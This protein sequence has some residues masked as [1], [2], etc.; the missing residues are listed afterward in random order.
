MKKSLEYFFATH[1]SRAEE[2]WDTAM[3]SVDTNVLLGMFRLTND[4]ANKLMQTL[5]ECASLKEKNL[6]LTKQVLIEF[7]SNIRMA[8][9]YAHDQF[10][11]SE[12]FLENSKNKLKSDIY[13]HLKSSGII[14]EKTIKRLKKSM[15]K[16][17]DLVISELKES[18]K[19]SEYN[20]ES[21]LK[22]VE[23]LQ[24]IFSDKVLTH[25]IPSQ[26]DAQK[27][28]KDGHAPSGKD[29]Q[30]PSSISQAGDAII[31]LELIEHAKILS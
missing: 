30:K 28:I 5:E 16:E 20:L 18:Q 19:S 11:K 6:F 9:K 31:W 22:I 3:L 10:K 12:E 17:I 1:P 13:G 2:A 26:E 14:P 25:E 27:L 7:K 15:N 4:T 21:R 29:S 23:R 8:M 24:E